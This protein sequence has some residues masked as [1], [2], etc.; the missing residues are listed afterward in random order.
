MFLLAIF[1]LEV[2]VGVFLY[3]NRDQAEEITRKS[4]TIVLNDYANKTESRAFFDEIQHDVSD[5][6]CNDYTKTMLKP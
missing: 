2:A 3:I 1:L 6:H 4:M 5:K